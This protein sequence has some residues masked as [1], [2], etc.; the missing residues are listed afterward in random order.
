MLAANNKAFAHRY[1]KHMGF[2]R[3]HRG[4]AYHLLPSTSAFGMWV[5]VAYDHL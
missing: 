2:V 1:I 3:G 4:K 5:M